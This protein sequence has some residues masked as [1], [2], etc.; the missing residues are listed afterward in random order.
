MDGLKAHVAT[1]IQKARD[2][3][4]ENS[5]AVWGLGGVN[6]MYE[7]QKLIEKKN[8]RDNVVMDNLE[9]SF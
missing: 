2:P 7:N 8:E 6:L 5:W 4:V 9:R 1:E 3:R